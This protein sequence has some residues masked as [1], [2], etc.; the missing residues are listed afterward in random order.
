M[1]ILGQK[2]DLNWAVRLLLHAM[3]LYLGAWMVINGLNHWLPIF[4][5]PFGG[6]ALSQLYLTSLVD[7]GLFGVAK[8][9][10]VIGGVLL[11][12]NLFT[13]FGLAI[14]LP[15]SLMVYFNATYLQG[16]W[17][18]VWAD[19]GIYMG[20]VC[21]YFN[22]IL[23][24]TYLRYYLPILS[25]RSTMGSLGDIG[26]L[27]RIGGD[28]AERQ[29]AAHPGLPTP[30]GTKLAVLSIGAGIAF[31][32]LVTWQQSIIADFSPTSGKTARGF[33][34]DYLELAYDKGQGAK[35]R[36]AF[37]APDAKDHAPDAIDRTD[38]VPIPHVVHKIVADGMTVAVYQHIGATR[39]APAMDVVDIYEADRFS[40]IRERWRIVQAERAP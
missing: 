22:L 28:L 9:I 35:A 37:F 4:P 10:E 3:R 15:V 39:G 36:T 18:R 14:L 13:P 8:A 24:V 26:L 12:L 16:R 5:Q 2:V 27:S 17:F 25:M 33:I 34:G 38:G 30:A 29:D 7:T 31:C 23:M 32:L 19:N 20:T 21:L 40:R 11:I 1:K 6:T